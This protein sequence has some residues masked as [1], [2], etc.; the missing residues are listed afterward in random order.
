MPPSKKLLAA[1]IFLFLFSVS[2]F[3][4]DSLGAVHVWN[5]VSKKLEEGKYELTFGGSITGNWQVYAPNQTLLNEKTIVLKFADS[6]IVQVGDFITQGTPKEIS[7]VIVENSKVS[8]YESSLQWKAVIKIKGTVPSKLQGTLFY[9]YGINDE[10]YPSTEAG[11][12]TAMEGGAEAASIKI[13]SININKPI[14]SCGDDGTKNK[15]L[16]TI[17]FSVC[18]VE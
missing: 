5:V 1:F 8:V 16:V 15:S 17:S 13:A 14:S 9:T 3:S 6:N 7:S 11:F 12:V 18:L 4:Q 2:G 10:Y